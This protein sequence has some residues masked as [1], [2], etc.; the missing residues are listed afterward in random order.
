MIVVGR[1]FGKAW[2]IAVERRARSGLTAIALSLDWQ[3]GD[4]SLDVHLD[5]DDTRDRRR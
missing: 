1:N 5:D 4:G 3:R 2:I